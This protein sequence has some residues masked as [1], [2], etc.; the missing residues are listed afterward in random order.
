MTFG[1]VVDALQAG[2]TGRELN[3]V[4]PT[5]A[6]Q[7]Y[8]NE[9]TADFQAAREVLWE[10]ISRFYVSK[11]QLLDDTKDTP[12]GTTRPRSQLDGLIRHLYR[13]QNCIHFYQAR[14]YG[15]FIRLTDFRLRFAKE[16]VTLRDAITALAND[17]TISIG[18]AIEQ[19]ATAG[20][21]QKRRSANSLSRAE[22]LCFIIA[23]SVFLFRNFKIC[24]VIARGTRPSLHNIRLRGENTDK[25]SSF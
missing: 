11:D 1:A 15:E 19:A 21:V 8:I 13:I 6:M 20:L 16:K 12:D 18:D 5:M 7:A 3:K 10:Q 17:T 14:Q 22:R 2:K 24:I 4:S 23:S 9:H 25:F